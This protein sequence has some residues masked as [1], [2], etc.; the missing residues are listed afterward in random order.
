MA[1]IQR[2]AFL[3]VVQTAKEW[4]AIW[5]FEILGILSQKA[6]DIQAMMGFDADDLRPHHSQPGGALRGSQNPTEICD[7]DA[8]ERKRCHSLDPPCGLDHTLSVQLLGLLETEA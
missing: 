4:R 5:S 3:A 8:F 1:Q 7:T 6:N 2:D